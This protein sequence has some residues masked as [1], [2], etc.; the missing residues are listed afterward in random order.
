MHTKKNVCG[1]KQESPNKPFHGTGFINQVSYTKSSGVKN[2]LI[3]T[4]QKQKNWDSL[5][6]GTYRHLIHVRHTLRISPILVD[7][8]K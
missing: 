4:K 2:F 7:C 3:E 5:D 6:Q 1:P 8:H